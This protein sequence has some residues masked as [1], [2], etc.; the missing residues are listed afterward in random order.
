M[1]TGKARVR[2]QRERLWRQ[3]AV[4]WQSDWSL[5]V[6]LALLVGNVF[7]VPLAQF[8]T[9][10]RLA[11]RTILSLIIISGIVASVR[12]PRL[13]LVLV[14]ITFGSLLVGWED[15][16]RPNIYLHLLN[17]LDALVFIAFLAV[18]ILRQALRAGRITSR[19]VQGSV[20]VYLLLGLLW[21]VSYDV[22]ELL[23]PGSFSSHTGGATAALPEL[24]YFSFTTLTTLGLGDVLPLSPLARS[25]TMLE[26]LVGQLFPVILIT[27][28]VAMEIEYSRTGRG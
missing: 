28:L 1:L 18:L 20:A 22:I 7:V 2:A 13:V 16:R 17:D 4:F 11:G 12:N 6:L 3:A 9:W 15:F 10:G 21:A 23:Q 8:A 26:G 25:F 14:G 24:A 27:R 5:T 19:R